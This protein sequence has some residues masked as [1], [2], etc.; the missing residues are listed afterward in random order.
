MDRSFQ[1]P[2][3]ELTEEEKLYFLMRYDSEVLDFLTQE[4]IAAIKSNFQLEGKD[5]PAPPGM[6]ASQ[7]NQARNAERWK[8]IEEQIERG[9]VRPDELALLQSIRVDQVGPLN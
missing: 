8:E 1:E 9:E 4:D 7:L 6:T 2:S 3:G 5:F